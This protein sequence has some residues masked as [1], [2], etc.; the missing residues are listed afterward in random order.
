MKTY[1]RGIFSYKFR[2][3]PSLLQQHYD[4]PCTGT[5]LVVLMC[6]RDAKRVCN[7]VPRDG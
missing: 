3:Q 2:C 4:K 1:T 5:T 6:E 7:F